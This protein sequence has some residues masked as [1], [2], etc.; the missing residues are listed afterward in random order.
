MFFLKHSFIVTFSTVNVI[1]NTVFLFLLH[2]PNITKNDNTIAIN[3]K[4]VDRT[5]LKALIKQ[6]ALKERRNSKL[7]FSKTKCEDFQ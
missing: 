7:Q 6:A 3:D 1:F 4:Y 2:S 5:L